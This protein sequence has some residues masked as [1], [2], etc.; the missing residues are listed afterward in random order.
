MSE[1]VTFLLI[2]SPFII[3]F[4]VKE[5]AFN[6]LPASHWINRTFNQRDGSDGGSGGWF[7]GDGGDCGD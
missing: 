2:I 5:Y 7:D 4:A 6:V 1:T 3:L